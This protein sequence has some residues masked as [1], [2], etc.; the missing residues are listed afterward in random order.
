M[1][2]AKRYAVAA[3]MM[4]A[5]AT[6]SIATAMDY[7]IYGSLRG[8][9]YLLDESA[10]S[11]VP[12]ASPADADFAAVGG[13]GTVVKR[14][15]FEPG[16]AYNGLVQVGPS[17]EPIE[18]EAPESQWDWGF[19]LPA[20]SRIG[21]EGKQD[22]GNGMTSGFHWETE[23]L[24]AG[25]TGDGRLANVWVEGAASR[26][27]VGQQ[28]NPYRNAAH[29]D[30]A[31]FLGGNNRYGDGGTR[32]QGARLD[33]GTG[34]FR[35][36]VMATAE[37]TNQGAVDIDIVG[38]KLVGRSPPLDQLRPDV[39]SS[40]QTQNNVSFDEVNETGIDSWMTTLHYA[41]DHDYVDAINM[42]Y[43]SDYAGA[44]AVGESYDNFVVSAN[45]HYGAWEWYAGWERNSD[46]A[47]AK[48]TTVARANLDDLVE[49]YDDLLDEINDQRPLPPGYKDT[50]IPEF[51]A[52]AKALI[53]AD[54]ARV[55]DVTNAYA[56]AQDTKTLG[57]FLAY[58][59]NE[60]SKVYFELEDTA[61]S[62]VDVVGDNLD[63]T[64]A[65]LGYSLRLGRHSTFIAE[66]LSLDYNSELEADSGALLGVFKVDF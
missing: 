56:N 1:K 55:A 54:E 47:I 12:I 30:Q 5:M 37:E 19:D 38:E 4:A 20:Y 46:N 25:D 40:V 61:N 16:V 42:G 26:L 66:Y 52:G 24:G 18:G 23:I 31:W 51:R 32:L 8:G 7:S 58:N 64:A 22:I 50:A 35:F 60:G 27:T 53:E 45:G 14:A 10:K 21:I 2:H 11:T 17:S 65:L 44:T 9:V 13:D 63:K 48:R 62:G 28:E 59:L 3:S 43:R 6:S 41:V 49:S 39:S 33:G 15:D 34:K 57:L 36:S 29:W